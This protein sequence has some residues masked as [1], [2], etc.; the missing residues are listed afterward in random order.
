MY[1]RT[2]LKCHNGTSPLL[3]SYGSHPTKAREV[4]T[5]AGSIFYYARPTVFPV[6]GSTHNSACR[7]AK[8][9]AVHAKL[10]RRQAHETVASW[11]LPRD[12]GWHW[13]LYASGRPATIR[14]FP[15][16][17]KGGSVGG[18][19]LTEDTIALPEGEGAA[20]ISRS[21]SIRS[22]HTH[23]AAVIPLPLGAGS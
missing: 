1:W 14:H 18:T 22:S 3:D 2:Q 21:H 16:A 7:L 23:E 15:Y 4:S 19:E 20:L 12:V 11:R 13:G 8:T 5:L 6:Y 17:V 9:P 10:G